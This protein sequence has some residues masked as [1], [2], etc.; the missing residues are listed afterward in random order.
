MPIK[1]GSRLEYAPEELQ[2]NN[3]C[4][5]DAVV[6]YWQGSYIPQVEYGWSVEGISKASASSSDRLWV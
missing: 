6:A 4:G 5:T 2:G 1:L 3:L